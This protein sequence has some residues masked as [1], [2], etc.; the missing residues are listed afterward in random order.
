MRSWPLL[1]LLLLPGVPAGAQDV[2]ASFAVVLP[3]GV[4]D[5]R[6]WEVV[7]GEF[8]T[9]LARGSYLFYVNPRRQAMYQLMRYRL[10]LLAPSTALERR[11]RSGERVAFVRGPG[12][13]EPLLCWEREA[14]GTVPPW[15]EVVAGTDEYQLEM[16]LLMQVLAV[17]RA[18]RVS[19][20]R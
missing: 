8:E 6:G 9:A 17:H 10:E 12:T 20:A 16:A 13:R 11:R 19:Q 2:S 4:A 15:R 1:A 5:V 14:E 3:D 7:S 18:A